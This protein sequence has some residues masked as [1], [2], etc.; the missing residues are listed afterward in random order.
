MVT[1]EQKEI[2]KQYILAHLDEYTLDVNGDLVKSLDVESEH[3]C[4]Y[5][6]ALDPEFY[7]EIKRKLNK[8][9]EKEK[10]DVILGESILADLEN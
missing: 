6:G 9:E 10:K 1:S 2:N 3:F 5:K 8:V 4:I 7:R